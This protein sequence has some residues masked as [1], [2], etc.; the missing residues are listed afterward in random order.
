M[1][2]TAPSADA[3]RPAAAKVI[4][5]EAE[6]LSI[7]EAGVV[8]NCGRDTVYRLLNG[9][10]LKSVLLLSVRRIRRADLDAFLAAMPEAG[11]DA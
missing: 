7:P 2:S 4:P 11:A 6:L 9:G 5:P 1:R 3:P 8:L 10:Q